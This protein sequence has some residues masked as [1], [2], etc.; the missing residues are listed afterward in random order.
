MTYPRILVLAVVLCTA[1]SAPGGPAGD[2]YGE[3][4]PENR[5]ITVEQLAAKVGC[6]PKIQ[7]EAAELRQ[8][9]CATPMGEF[10]LT[11]FATQRGKDEWMDAAPEYNPHL[12]GH[13]WTALSSRDVLERVQRKIGGDLHLKDHRTKT[14]A[15]G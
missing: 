13:L 9:H 2:G 11:T 3:A 14:P 15:P 12:V 8:A 1:C 6:R 10:F 4:A 7:I 5:P